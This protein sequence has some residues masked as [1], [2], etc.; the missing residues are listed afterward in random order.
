MSKVKGGEITDYC[1]IG[2][3]CQETDLIGGGQS[4]GKDCIQLTNNGC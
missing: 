4:C 3:V 2:V 1:S